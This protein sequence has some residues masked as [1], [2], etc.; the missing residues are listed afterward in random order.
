MVWSV[1]RIGTEWAARFFSM[2]Q[3]IIDSRFSRRQHGQPG[4][5]LFADRRMIQ[6]PHVSRQDKRGRLPVAL[7]P[8][9]NRKCCTRET[10]PF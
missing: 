4:Y 1:T 5:M 3:E 6:Q 8:I 2:A 9:V 7:F 10:S